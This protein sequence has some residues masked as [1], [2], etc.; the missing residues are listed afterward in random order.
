[1]NSSNN[2]KNFSSSSGNIWRRLK[3]YNN[4]IPP[5]LSIINPHPKGRKLIEDFNKLT[6][7]KNLEN[8]INT[9]N[10]WNINNNNSTNNNFNI[11]TNNFSFLTPSNDKPK[12]EEEKEKEKEKEK[13]GEKEKEKENKNVYENEIENKKESEIK[14][15]IIK[16]NKIAIDDNNNE[17]DNNT[18]IITINNHNN[19][20]FTDYGLGYKCNCQKTQCNKNYCQCFSE[21]RYCFN[22][23]CIDCN[24][25]KP[26]YFATNKHQIEEENKDKKGIS[27][28]CTCT[29]SGCNK[30]YCE[31]FKNKI[32]CNS[33]CRCRNCENCEDGKDKDE[34]FL[35]FQN[36][37][38]CLANSVFI[39][40]NKIV[41]EDVNKY[42]NIYTNN[43][44]K[45]VIKKQINI[46]VNENLLSSCS[47]EEN[48]NFNGHKRKRDNNKKMDIEKSISN[49]KSK[50]S[51]ENTDETS[52]L[53]KN[54]KT[55]D[56]L[57]DKN[58]KLI[59][60]NFKF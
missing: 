25:K 49:K 60:T 37:K 35:N 56:N 1:M 53:K 29:K 6:D 8:E 43:K 28:A 36:F 42:K 15:E 58:G 33:L 44:K 13:E 17:N 51:D 59:L 3:D 54:N 45:D 9:I 30:N 39:I 11:S 16:N 47:S 34:K 57:F 12:K 5:I 48:E 38:C 2:L 55:E 24:N 21:G 4:N 27:I 41:F 50:I 52:K 18:N 46:T 10:N 7:N 22:C 40:K 20:F 23:N 32:K 19:M 14:K 26:E 31:C